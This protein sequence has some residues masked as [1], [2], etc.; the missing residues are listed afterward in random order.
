MGDIV[1]YGDSIVLESCEINEPL[2]LGIV[3]RCEGRRNPMLLSTEVSEADKHPT[4]DYQWRVLPVVGSKRKWGDPV[5]FADRIRLQLVDDRGNS[6]MLAV[7]HLDNRSIMAERQPAK[8]DACIWWLSY[9]ST[10]KFNRDG[11]AVPSGDLMPHLEYGA[12]N[13]LA[14]LNNARYLSATDDH[15]GIL[16]KRTTLLGDLPERGTAIWWRAH[17]SLSDAVPSARHVANEAS[18]RE[19]ASYSLSVA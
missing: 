13:Y 18:A 19:T 10:L 1:C 3:R 5:S 6:R 11:R 4:S 7:S 12:S 9:T 2:F 17:R 16:R 8:M 15:Y 14:L